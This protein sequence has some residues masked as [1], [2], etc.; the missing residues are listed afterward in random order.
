MSALGDTAMERQAEV[1]IRISDRHLP[2]HAL[3]LHDRR[4]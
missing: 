1:T 4:A 2:K 3:H